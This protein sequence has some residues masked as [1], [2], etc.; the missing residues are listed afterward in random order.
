MKWSTSVGFIR[1]MNIHT[2]TIIHNTIAAM[3]LMIAYFWFTLF[4]KRMVVCT[5][6]GK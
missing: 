4:S 1:Y 2:N 3:E 6:I 5:H